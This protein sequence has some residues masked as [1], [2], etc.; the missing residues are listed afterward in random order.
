MIKSTNERVP[1]VISKG[2]LRV[3]KE[4]TFMM[5]PLLRFML[6]LRRRATGLVESLMFRFVMLKVEDKSP[7]IR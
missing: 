7:L 5:M 3:L 2:S 4:E 6:E 1:S